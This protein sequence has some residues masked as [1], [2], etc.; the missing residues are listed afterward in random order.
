MLYHYLLTIFRLIRKGK[1]NFA[2]KLGGLSLAMFCL[3]AIAI[4]VGYQLSFD[5]FHD[6]YKNV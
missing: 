1:V 3:M 6:D 5:R 2:F 4:F